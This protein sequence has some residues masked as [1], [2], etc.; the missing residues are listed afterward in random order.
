M[1][2][3]FFKEP[4]FHF[5]ILG[6]LIFAIFYALQEE[7][8]AA[9]ANEIT[10]SPQLVERLAAQFQTSWRRAPTVSEA[11]SLID[12]YVNEEIMVREA[13]ALS[14]DAGDTV[15]RQRLRQK[16]QFIF[17]SAAAAIPPTDEALQQYFNDNQDKYTLAETLAFEQVFL[18]D[19]PTE[20]QVAS[21]HAALAAGED[22]ATLGKATLLAT[23]FGAMAPQKLDGVMGA[24]VFE[25]LNALDIGV[26]VGPI[27][28]GYGLH[29]VR[30]LE[31]T[32][33]KTHA[34]DTIRDRIVFDW[35]A[36]LAAEMTEK[37]IQMVRERYS[38]DLPSAGDIEALLK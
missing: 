22:P 37:Q 33:A 19:S 27:R 20:A 28:S 17:E 14:L 10:V 34:F 15:I 32:A 5:L 8:L 24:G 30:V 18:G 13:K 9:P 3:R 12:S 23:H 21:I 16:M 11:Q 2:G 25:A 29:L 26:W 36:D 4:L 38:I 1:L 31:H 6:A 35:R 7:Q